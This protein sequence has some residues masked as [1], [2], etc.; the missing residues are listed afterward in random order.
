[1]LRRWI[2]RLIVLLGPVAVFGCAG[3]FPIPPMPPVAERA[4][5]RPFTHPLG[6]EFV[7]IPT[8]G[9]VSAQFIGLEETHDPRVPY[10]MSAHPI[11]NAQYEAFVV[12]YREKV[13]ERDPEVEIGRST[14]ELDRQILEHERHPKS[15][16]DDHPVNN[17]TPEMADAFCR[18]LTETDPEGRLF[19]LPQV[20]EWS[21]A[22]RGGHSYR[23]YPWGDEIDP[24]KACY[25]ADSTEPVGSYPPNDFGL[26][27]VVGNVAEWN[28]NDGYPLYTLRG[29]SWRDDAEGLKFTRVGREPGRESDEHGFR[30]YGEPPEKNQ[31]PD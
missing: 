8:A 6:I 27:D 7:V 9:P 31:A 28:I 4:E 25:D 15:P 5:A 13:E 30:V 21:Y 11:T 14:R 24:S 20:D 18:W 26:Y 16:G 3:S 1:M 2:F 12:A 17:V 19:R 22:A 10:L 23:L 29:G